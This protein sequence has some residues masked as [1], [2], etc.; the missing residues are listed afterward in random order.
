MQLVRE[1]VSKSA[2]AHSSA[3]ILAYERLCCFKASQFAG[4]RAAR[5]VFSYPFDVSLLHAPTSCHVENL[6]VFSA[7]SISVTLCGSNKYRF[8]VLVNSGRP[9]KNLLDGDRAERLAPVA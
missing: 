9:S 2:L 8:E 7:V 1:R 5:K 4:N 6:P 3:C